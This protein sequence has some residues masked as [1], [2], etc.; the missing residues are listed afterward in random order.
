MATESD[1]NF[2]SVSADELISGGAAKVHEVF[3]IATKY[4]PAV[5]FIDELDAVGSHRNMI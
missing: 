2:L 5:L 4:A 1:V 3:R